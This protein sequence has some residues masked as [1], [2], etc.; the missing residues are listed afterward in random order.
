MAARLTLTKDWFDTGRTLYAYL[1]L[2]MSFLTVLLKKLSF[3]I[4]PLR[5]SLSLQAK[6]ME[7]LSLLGAF[8]QKKLDMDRNQRTLS[9]L[10]TLFCDDQPLYNPTAATR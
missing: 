7:A 5:K 3:V 2:S 1:F 10:P 9:A 4:F 6:K 8:M